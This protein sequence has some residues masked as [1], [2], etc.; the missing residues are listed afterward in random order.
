MKVDADGQTVTVDLVVRWAFRLVSRFPVG[1]RAGDLLGLNRDFLSNH[2]QSII[3]TGSYC[4]SNLARE[5]QTTVAGAPGVCDR[6]TVT[7]KSRPSEHLVRW[8]RRQG[9]YKGPMRP[10]CVDTL[11]RPDH[12]HP[13]W[14]RSDVGLGLGGRIVL[15]V[16]RKPRVT[17]RW[18]H[19]P[20]CGFG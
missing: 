1:T 19:R 11:W 16:R 5:N 10:W 4:F 13:A 12:V 18:S 15:S 6:V 17:P 20:E 7:E 14:N 3:A 8:I 2:S 9:Q